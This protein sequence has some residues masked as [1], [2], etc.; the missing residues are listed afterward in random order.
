M[1]R[2]WRIAAL[3]LSTLLVPLAASAQ[4]TA[5]Q[6]A[7]GLVKPVFLTAPD[8]DT[9]R[10]FVVE[11]RGTIQIVKN[12]FVNAT[13]F[14]DIQGL[15]NSSGNEQGLL[16]L[17]FAPDYDTSGEFY[18]YYTAG[19]GAGFSVISRFT[20][21]ADPDVA[22]PFS[23]EPVFRTAQFQ[24]NHNGGTIDFG[25]DGYLYFLMG[26]GGSASDPGNR[27]QNPLV[28]LGKALR[29][30]PTGDDYPGD[31]NNNYAIPPSNP[32]VGNPAGLDE[33]WAIGLRNPYRWSF[34]RLT[35]DMY[36]GDVGQECWEEISF[37]P[38]ASTGG[39]N[40]GWR[41]VEG[42]HCFNPAD[43]FNCNQPTNC[44]AG[45][46]DPIY[47]YSSGSG[48]G[49]CSVT[50]GYVYRGN[51]IPAF[52]GHYIFADYCSNQITSFRWDG[53]TLQDFTNRTAE[54]DGPSFTINTIT[55]FG[56][57]G[58][59]ELYILDQGGQV[60][61]IIPDPP[62]G[63]SV[64]PPSSSFALSK[65]RPN[66]FADGTRFELALASPGWVDVAVYSAS[67]RLVRRVRQGD[68]AA[69]THSIEW[70]GRDAADRPLPAGVYFVRAVSGDHVSTQTVTL[71]R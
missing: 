47:D 44:S 10:L 51:A 28:L 57:D 3:T 46:V 56:E 64:V 38:A 69:G 48:S 16:G 34:D 11:A 41:I 35:G 18:V 52:Q 4:I 37:Q 25:P 30:D 27:A 55:G 63:V 13:P 36:I 65:G 29:I 5:E 68:L 43:R 19:A 2:S 70:L 50:G 54:L 32:Y 26:D 53:S 21:T 31:A 59:G 66:P 1:S 62:V 23:V 24:T 61:K 45:L 67:G 8:G 71:V 40:Y 39:E 15:V 12:G 7:T 14:L 17:C 33:I 49:A 42:T 9:E 58:I 60:Y 22:D 20:V 6:V